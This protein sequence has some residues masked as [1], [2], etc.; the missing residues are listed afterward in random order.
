MDENKITVNGKWSYGA[1]SGGKTTLYEA[2]HK[3]GAI[4]TSFTESGW[5]FKD[6]YF[7]ITGTKEQIEKFS[8]IHKK[9]VAYMNSDDHG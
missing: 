4:I 3:S 5:L 7:T 6:A 8:N 9:I 1:L 2:A